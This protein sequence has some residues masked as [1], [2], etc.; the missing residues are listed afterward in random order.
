MDNKSK[1]LE[2]DSYLKE[3]KNHYPYIS[4]CHRMLLI[5]VAV[6]SGYELIDI[7]RKKGCWEVILTCNKTVRSTTLLGLLGKLCMNE[8]Y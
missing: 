3:G 8:V 4:H 7:K 6:S 2:E 1:K 5:K